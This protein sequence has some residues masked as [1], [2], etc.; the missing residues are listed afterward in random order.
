MYGYSAA[1]ALGQPLSHFIPERFRTG[2]SAQVNEFG[3]TGMTQ[4]SIP[5]LSAIAGLRA[6][7]EE[8]PAEA[9][10]SKKGSALSQNLYSHFARPDRAA[11]G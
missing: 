4:W 11:A 2:H 1:A 7:G 9:A 3:R 10:I 6:N 8:F 5:A